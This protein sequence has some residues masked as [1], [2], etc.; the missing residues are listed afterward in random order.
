MIIPSDMSDEEAI[1]SATLLGC[2]FYTSGTVWI[3]FDPD[4][5]MYARLGNNTIFF[6]TKAA[7]ARAYLI[8]IKP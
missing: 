2:E 8:R 1:A 5:G 7:A 3:S 6:P 4:N